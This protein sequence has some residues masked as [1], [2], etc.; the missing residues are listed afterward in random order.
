MV[1]EVKVKS[2]VMRDGGKEK[3]WEERSTTCSNQLNFRVAVVLRFRLES[4]SRDGWIFPWST[5]SVFVGLYW[6]RK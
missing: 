5:D 6:V 3:K 1:E 2:A 4:K